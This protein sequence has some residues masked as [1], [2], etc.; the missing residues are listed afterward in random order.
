[1]KS[2]AKRQLS[3]FESGIAL[4]L[5]AAQE[6]LLGKINEANSAAAI[7]GVLGGSRRYL[8]LQS[9]AFNEVSLLGDFMCQELARY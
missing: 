9:I 4:K 2:K 1:M 5:V 6:E 3:H 8:E 7:K